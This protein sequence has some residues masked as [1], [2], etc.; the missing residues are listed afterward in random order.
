MV[1]TFTNLWKGLN[2][3]YNDFIRTTEKRHISIVERVLEILYRKGDIY[4]AEYKGWYCTP[5][6]T[7]WTE[8][9]TQDQNCPDC[10]R[11]VEHISERNYFFRLSNYQDW[12]IDYINKNPN[13]I[14]PEIRRRE[15]LS[16]LEF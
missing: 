4:E 6:E 11:P 13:F 14:R 1:L 7:F 16:F 3:S 15:V 12:L 9:Q 10:K 2:I 5:C 8:N